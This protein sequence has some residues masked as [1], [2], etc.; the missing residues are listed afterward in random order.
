M[1]EA[2]AG[3]VTVLTGAGI[4]TESGIPDFRGPRG[5]WTLNPASQRLF[6]YDAYVA[7]KDVRRQAWML[8]REH[9]AWTAEPNAGHLA[10]VDLERSGR[11]GRL[12]TQNIDGLH[13]KAG[14]TSDRVL[15][16]HGTI[17]QT[18][19]LSCRRLVPTP[20]VLARLDA[21]E[22]DPACLECGGILKVATISFGQSLD[23]DVL[24]AAI[25]AT[26]GCAL[27][28]AVGTS[29]SVQPAASL[30]ALATRSGGRLVIVNAEPTPYDELAHAVLRES[31]GTVLPALVAGLR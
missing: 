29:L 23:A 15:E 14:N 30:A 8:R 25:E 2:R 19:C 28:L 18:E 1:A 22:D 13:Q 17:H 7:D 10:L 20:Q 16:M 6:D 12:V 5:L 31:V 9:P 27:F 11:L 4:S 3:E 24:D 26:T 21:G